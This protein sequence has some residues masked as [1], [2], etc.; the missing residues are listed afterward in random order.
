[1]PLQIPNN[2]LLSETDIFFMP[3]SKKIPIN[4]TNS[5]NKTCYI[6]MIDKKDFDKLKQLDKQFFGPQNED[7][8]DV[9]DFFD[10]L[11]SLPDDN[12]EIWN[13]MLDRLYYLGCYFI[14]KK[15]YED[16]NN[17]KI[18]EKSEFI[19]KILTPQ[20]VKWLEYWLHP[21]VRTQILLHNSRDRTKD[22]NY[23]KVERTTNRNC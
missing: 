15:D 20:I 16:G 23:N 14:N 12:V 21:S 13:M 9:M 8:Y 4:E 11:M 2:I 17:K 10:G 6:I 3:K 22:A 5:T 7:T 19:A 1:M 18:L